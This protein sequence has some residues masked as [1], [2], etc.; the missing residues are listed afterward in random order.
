MMD[1]VVALKTLSVA[2][3]K[4]DTIQRFFREVKAAARLAHPNIVTAYDAGEHAGTHYL[5]MEYVLGRDLAAI[6]KEKG[7][8]P[9]RLAIDYVQQTARG[10]AYA[11]EHGV[12]HRDVKPGNLLLNQEGMVKILDM[13]LAR[14]NENPID[15]PVAMDIT[16]TG[17]IL[18]TIDYMSPEQAEDVHSAD[19]RSDIYSLG[20]TLFYLLTRRPVY[21]GETVVKRILAHRDD[22]IPSVLELRPDCPEI[23]DA[24]ICRMLAKRPE[25]RPQAMSEIIEELESCLARPGAAPPP[26]SP[27]PERSG[28][29]PNW[30][31]DL[32]Q[33]DAAPSTDH[34]QARNA[35]IDFPA[36]DDIHTR[37]PKSSIGGSTIRR[38]KKPLPPPAA[39][40]PAPPTGSNTWKI[41]TAATTAAAILVAIVLVLI[42]RHPGGE[43]TPKKG[44]PVEK[45]TAGATVPDDAKN[46]GSGTP[47][48]TPNS[49]V[50]GALWEADWADTKE[51]AG[52]M[53]AEQH[54]GK[55]I[56]EYKNL[57]DRFHDPQS[58]QQC[59]EAIHNIEVK[60]DAAYGKAES[61]ARERLSQRQYAQA[62]AA[63]QKAFETYGSVPAS[64]RAQKLMEEIDQAEKPAPS[65]VAKP[66]TANPPNTPALSPELIKQRELDMTYAT[67]MT[68]VERRVTNWDFQGAAQESEKVHFALP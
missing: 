57:A 51:R 39:K 19:H 58:Q 26:V 6:V 42:F 24:T 7:A 52:Q 5:V 53:T 37:P 11:H 13:G 60:A 38:S 15:A 41:V 49:P 17:Q 64:H 63:L 59:K 12:V 27:L 65:E 22:P 32:V 31:D 28:E 18:G 68:A 54:F 35:T 1:R 55:A 14:L 66:E 48:A 25:D 40:T 56:H 30:L 62:R 47:N 29:Q 33:D 2:S 10:L 20:C 67:A 46:G 44:S 36:M 21:A 9:L 43:P 16:G 23:L 34:A 8:L 61:V 3:I 45:T 4:P 50:R